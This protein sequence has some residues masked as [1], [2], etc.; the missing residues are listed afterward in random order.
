MNTYMNI[1][2]QTALQFLKFKNLGYLATNYFN[3]EEFNKS[4]NYYYV[5][6]ILYEYRVEI[7]LIRCS[8]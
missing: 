4:S 6:V 3:I 7:E 1:N 2:L 8:I 5:K